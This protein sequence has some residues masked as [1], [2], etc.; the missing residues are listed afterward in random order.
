MAKFIYFIGCV[1]V[2]LWLIPVLAWILEIL[3]KLVY[4]ILVAIAGLFELIW[5]EITWLFVRKVTIK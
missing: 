1:V 4:M 5:T 3:V 2:G